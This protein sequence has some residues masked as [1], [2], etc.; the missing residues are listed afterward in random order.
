[1]RSPFRSGWDRAGRVGGAS[2]S[3][4][5]PYAR[6]ERITAD[7]GLSGAVASSAGDDFHEL[8]AVREVL[9][10]LD[11]AGDFDEVKVEGVPADEAHRDLGDHAQAVDVTLRRAEPGAAADR[12]PTFHYAQLKHSSAAPD[13]SW[14]WERLLSPRNKSKPQSSVLGKLAGLIG[15]T[16]SAGTFAIVTNQPLAA[17]VHADVARLRGSDELSVKDLERVNEVASALR[18]DAGQLVPFLRAWDLSGFGTTSRLA[19]ETDVIRELGKMLDADARSDAGILQQR[20]SALILPENRDHAPINRETLMVWLGAGSTETLFP[21]P[22]RIVVPDPAFIVERDAVGEV[23]EALLVAGRP[24][25]IHS[26]GGCGKTSLVSVLARRLP[27][28][29]EMFVYDC[30]GGGLFLASDQR[31]HSTEQAFTQM[32][33][34]IAARLRTPFVVRREGSRDALTTFRSR[35]EAAAGLMA[36]DRPDGLLVICFDAVDNA[37]IGA[38]HWKERC[39][40]DELANASGW[41]ANVRI[42]VTCRT[43]RRDDVGPRSLYQDILIPAFAVAEVGELLDKWQPRWERG[44]AT[45]LHDLTGGNPRRLIYAVEGLPDDGAA[46]AIERLMPRATGIDP[47]FE[48]LVQAAAVRLGDP[49]SVWMLLGALA[50]LPRPTPGWVLAELAN[51]GTGDVAD[52]AADV[53]GLVEHAAGWSFQDEDFE[54]FVSERTEDMAPDLVGRAADLLWQ[55]R[56]EEHYAATAVAESLVAAGRTADLYALV[57]VPDDETPVSSR[58][59]AQLIA[60]RRL[61]LALRCCREAAD[62]ATACELLIASAEATSRDRMLEDLIASNLDLAVRFEPEAAMRLV[63][64]GARHREKRARLRVVMAASL[65]SDRPAIA[66]DHMRWWGEHLRDASGA[67]ARPLDVTASDLAAEYEATA[68]LAGPDRALRILRRRRPSAVSR[69]AVMLL[70]A[71]GGGLDPGPFLEA[72][73]AGPWTPPVS[74]ILLAAALLA[75]A[76]SDDLRIRREFRR[77]AQAPRARWPERVSHDVARS[78]VLDWQE[79]TLITCEWA[80]GTDELHPFVSSILDRVFPKP[81]LSDTNGLFNLRSAG[82]IHARVLSMRERLAGEPVVLREWFPPVRTVPRIGRPSSRELTARREKSAEE[83]WN[84]ALSATTTAFERLL[85]AARVITAMANDLIPVED[86]WSDFRSAIVRSIELNRRPHETTAAYLLVRRWILAVAQRGDDPEPFLKRVEDLLEDWGADQISWSVDLASALGHSPHGHEAALAIL[87]RTADRIAMRPARASER[88]KDLCACARTALPLDPELGRSLF[89]RAVDATDGVGS[90]VMSELAACQTVAKSGLGGDRRDRVEL[91]ERLADVAGAVNATIGVGGD[92]PWDET[93]AAVAAADLTTGLATA[94]RWRDRGLVPYRRT[95]PAL[96]TGP[97]RRGLTVAQR[98]ALAKLCGPDRPALGEF[99]SPSEAVDEATATAELREWADMGD[100]TR[101]RDASAFVE[102][103][104]LGAIEAAGMARE[105]LMTIEGWQGAVGPTAD[106]D[107]ADAPYDDAGPSG[108]DGQDGPDGSASLPTSAEADGRNAPSE[109]TSP[110]AIRATFASIDAREGGISASAMLLV[111]R[112]VRRRAMRLLFL[113]EVGRIAGGK[114]L[115]ALPG[116]LKGWRD[117]L[118]VADWARTELPGLLIGSLLDLFGWRWDDVST[119]EELLAATGLSTDGQAKV[120]LDAVVAN[121]D[122]LRADPIFSLAGVLASRTDPEDRHAL[123]GELLTRTRNRTVHEPMV[124]VTGADAPAAA[125]EAVAR[126]LFATM[127]DAEMQLRWRAAHGALDLLLADDPAA[128]SL[129]ACLDH[130]GETCFATQPFYVHAAREQLMVTLR[131]AAVDRPDLV[132]RHAERILAHVRRHPHLIIRESGRELLLHLADRDPSLLDATTRAE[133]ERLN[134]SQHP[135]VPP[136]TKPA[137]RMVSPSAKRERAFDF[138]TMDTTRYW[139]DKPAALFGMGIEEFLDH[140]EPWIH[141]KWGYGE[142]TSHWVNEPRR[143]R[144]EDAGGFVS[145]RQGARPSVERLSTYLEWH[146]MMCAVGELIQS[147]PLVARGP[148]DGRFAEWMARHLPTLG[149]A[150]ASDLRTPPPLERRFWGWSDRRARDGGGTHGNLTDEVFDLEI[151]GSSVAV[152]GNYDLPQ[153]RG[154]LHM[155]IR[156]AFVT[157]ETANALA[158]ALLTARDHMDFILPGLDDDNDIEEE[159]FRLVGWLEDD[160]SEVRMDRDDERRGPAGRL[161]VGPGGEIGRL[162]GLSFDIARR[163]WIDRAGDV[164]IDLAV[165]GHRDREGGEG[166]KASATPELIAEL[167]RVSG[168]DLMVTV[169]ITRSSDDDDQGSRTRWRVYVIDEGGRPRRVE[170]PGP[171]GA[172]LV[173]REGLSSSSDTL[174]RW[175]LHRAAELHDGGGA[176][177][178]AAAKRVCDRFRSHRAEQHW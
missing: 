134:R 99:A 9:R 30:Y 89:D 102:Q 23:A 8:W 143:H 85:G 126:L 98:H 104:G 108:T 161:P 65:A 53:G 17:V 137:R 24:L 123:L 34:E 62:V 75:N 49:G 50:R 84:D 36:S 40:V 22:S 47:L 119:L 66:R 10:L 117:Y 11:P 160:Q 63:L 26:G 12:S 100:H 105:A 174:G 72:M 138:D 35:V 74:A 82:A 88:V 141:G 78:A 28:G 14:T 150:W 139:Y 145:N 115:A 129:A 175:M 20:L 151:G 67:L 107:D 133:V 169:E 170:R 142:G 55:R 4:E 57:R 70:A 92:F 60:S 5:R 101:L 171:L 127:G 73:D 157:R 21:A 1:M 94:S 29:S 168:M 116:I 68:Q 27:A 39:F 122:I 118:P 77:L 147:H 110:E 33:N 44:M 111:S 113:R 87:L 120:V 153:G 103:A 58:I 61:A 38:R 37:R 69:R 121:A 54:H 6:R 144:L 163:A 56:R 106:D 162:P 59:E 128:A 42:V 114:H 148:N 79:A 140:V 124:V 81:E 13:Q 52:V 159:G 136:G 2:G 156:S 96:L 149:A 165:W 177:A 112:Q 71:R 131:R 167:V 16:G 166:W 76:G 3:R 91:A 48:K 46:S 164:A 32:S 130:D 19:I 152:A 93:I 154:S 90:E 15:A 86:A 135:A 41:P 125:G 83:R 31:R 158:G 64:A 146:G 155:N 45:T 80:L 172:A 132:A 173:R 178:N 95:L 51:I 18:I 109:L 25:R 176:D 7:Q 43:N 97:G